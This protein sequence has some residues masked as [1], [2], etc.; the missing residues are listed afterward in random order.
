[1]AGSMR[2]NGT[3]IADADMLRVTVNSYLAEGGDGFSV[4]RHGRDQSGGPLDVEALADYLSRQ[5]AQAPLAP[6]SQARIR[7]A[8]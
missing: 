1:M 2:L 8:P 3:P 7:R 4:L 6:D 5:S